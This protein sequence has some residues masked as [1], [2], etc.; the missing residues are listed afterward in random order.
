MKTVNNYPITKWLPKTETSWLESE[1]ERIN[2]DPS[3]ETIIAE[4]G[5]GRVSLIENKPVRFTFEG[6]I[7][8]C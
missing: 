6:N 2:K 5:K 1:M 8:F 4:D 7:E 3:R